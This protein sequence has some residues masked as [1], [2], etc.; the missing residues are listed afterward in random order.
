MKVLFSENYRKFMREI[1]E[2]TN[3]WKNIP[4]PWIGK[5][6]H[7]HGLEKQILLICLYYWKQSTYLM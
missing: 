3:K 5:T 1:E 7:A 2:D 6:S 4:C